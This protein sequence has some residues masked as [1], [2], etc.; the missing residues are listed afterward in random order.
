MCFVKYEEALAFN[1]MSLPRVFSPKT[2]IH[3]CSHERRPL[4]YS[5]SY[6]PYLMRLSFTRAKFRCRDNNLER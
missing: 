1:C 6:L 3:L 5:I 2:K 4:V